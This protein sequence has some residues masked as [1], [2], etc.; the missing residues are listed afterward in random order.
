[1]MLGGFLILLVRRLVIARVRR[2]TSV[3]DWVTFALL[4][5]VIGLG[6][7]ATVGR[8]LLGGG[9]EYRETVAPWFRG[10]FQLDP[11]VEGVAGAPLVYRMHTVA[12]FVLLGLWPY[13]RLVHAW[14]VPVMYLRRNYI[15]YRRRGPAPV[16]ESAAHATRRA[17]R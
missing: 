4:G 10:L 17:H 12:A 11:Q 5:I 3:M 6:M 9:Y 2:T 15:V 1:M 13:T 16:L 14:S 8:N 7:W